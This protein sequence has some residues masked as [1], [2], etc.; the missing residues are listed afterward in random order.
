MQQI[1][2]VI[3]IQILAIENFQSVGKGINNS[4]MKKISFTNIYNFFDASVSGPR[5]D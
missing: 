3:N 5:T 4:A 1:W 2:E